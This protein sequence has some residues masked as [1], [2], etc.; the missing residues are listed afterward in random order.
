MR[1]GAEAARHPRLALTVVCTGVFMAMLD[2]LAVTNALPTMG[3]EL[4]LGISGLQWAM[5]SYTLV[6]AST[7]LSAGT[8]GDLMG[9]RWAF[10]AG[11]IGFMAG[12]AIGSAAPTLAT[13]VAGRA[14]QGLGAA[15]LLPA[16]AAL[17]RH[18]YPDAAARARALGT[19]HRGHPADHR[20]A[21]PAAHLLPHLRPD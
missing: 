21:R 3:E 19:C 11:L 20:T 12:S 16:G 4:G 5:A 10:L 17:L 18:T 14:L 7:L 1:P 9:Q 13:L 15:V 8:V 6:L 2:N